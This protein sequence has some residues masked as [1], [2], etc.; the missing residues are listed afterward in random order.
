MYSIKN[1]WQIFVLT[2]IGVFFKVITVY[3]QLEKSSRTIETFPW[4]SSNDDVYLGLFNQMRRSVV[5]YFTLFTLT[6]FIIYN[7]HFIK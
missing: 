6:Y 2:I 1:N 5:I 3:R 7:L 4:R